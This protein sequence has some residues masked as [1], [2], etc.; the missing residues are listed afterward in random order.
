MAGGVGLAKVA[1]AS[2]LVRGA[3]PA[4]AHAVHPCHILRTAWAKPQHLGR[5]CPPYEA[6]NLSIFSIPDL[7]QIK[8]LA[9]V[10]SAKT[11]KIHILY[12]LRLIIKQTTHT[13]EHL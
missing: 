11:G 2:R 7:S 9:D 12:G 10:E 1:E 13:G 4:F 6:V 8:D 3:S 5:L